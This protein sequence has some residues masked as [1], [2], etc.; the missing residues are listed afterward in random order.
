MSFVIP[1]ATIHFFPPNSDRHLQQQNS[2]S[3]PGRR[4]LFPSPPESASGPPTQGID[5]EVVKAFETVM[6]QWE[7]I[8]SVK[9]RAEHVD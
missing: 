7:K 3:L 6:A 2:P 1:K 8:L 5:T 4:P 9:L